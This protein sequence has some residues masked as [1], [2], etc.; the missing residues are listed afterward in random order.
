M[1]FEIKLQDIAKSRH[2]TGRLSYS[3]SQFFQTRACIMAAAALDY[4]RGLLTV[5]TEKTM[6]EMERRVDPANNWQRAV[7]ATIHLDCKEAA[8]LII[9]ESSRRKKGSPQRTA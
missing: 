3:F 5:N 7:V 8:A 1:T 4:F 9:N 2:M 6:A